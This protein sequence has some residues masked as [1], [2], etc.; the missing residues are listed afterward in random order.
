[1][2]KDELPKSDST[3]KNG[4]SGSTDFARVDFVSPVTL[5]A[6]GTADSVY[7]VEDIG[8]AALGKKVNGIRKVTGGFEVYFEA[9][10]PTNRH[11]LNS[12]KKHVEQTIFVSFGSVKSG[13][14]KSA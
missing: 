3:P 2:A 13:I 7:S 9:D 11:Q 4:T 5:G 12:P 1:M 10:V 14:P 6:L 8:G